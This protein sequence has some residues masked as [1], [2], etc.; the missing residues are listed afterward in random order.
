MPTDPEA[1]AL[2]TELRAMALL[3]AGVDKRALARAS[4]ICDAL[5]ALDRRIVGQACD[6]A[7]ATIEILL[8]GR[9]WKPGAP[10]VEPL[11][12]A[13]KVACGR[14]RVRVGAARVVGCEPG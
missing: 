4:G 11:R 9:R 1:N 3:P 13:L 12:E 10:T 7:L 8:S 2:V 5:R 14:V 6:R